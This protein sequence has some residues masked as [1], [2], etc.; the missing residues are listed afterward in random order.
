MYYQSTR[1]VSLY[2]LPSVSLQSHTTWQRKNR[3]DLVASA[4]DAIFH[5]NH[6]SWHQFF[7]PFGECRSRSL[8]TVCCWCSVVS[9]EKMGVRWWCSSSKFKFHGWW[10]DIDDN[11]YIEILRDTW[12]YLLTTIVNQITVRNEHC[13]SQQCIRDDS[14]RY[15]WSFVLIASTY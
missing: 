3:F 15:A 4:H 2:E 9:G 6:N 14:I 10:R 12:V 1:R 13:A 11:R 7:L 8:S 5:S